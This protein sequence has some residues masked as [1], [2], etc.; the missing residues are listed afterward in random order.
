MTKIKDYI[1]GDTRLI[2]ITCKASDGTVLDLTGA[3]LVFTVSSSKTPAVSDIP[4]LQKTV[5]SH[6]NPTAGLTRVTINPADTAS[7][8]DGTYYYDVQV[9]D[10][11]GSVASLKQDTFTI[12]P[13]ITR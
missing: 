5:T 7:V 2:N 8:A 1:R 6:T 3:T 12:N 11:S 4:V 10:A 9:T 13:D